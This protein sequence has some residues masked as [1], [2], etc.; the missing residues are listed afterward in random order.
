MIASMASPLSNEWKLNWAK[1]VNPKRLREH[2]HGNTEVTDV[3]SKGIS[4]P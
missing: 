3:I 2:S 4:A 1:S